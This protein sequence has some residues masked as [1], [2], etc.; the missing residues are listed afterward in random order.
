[1][2][3]K[4]HCRKHGKIGYI[5]NIFGRF[6]AK[7]VTYLSVIF[8]VRNQ[9]TEILFGSIKKK[10]R[11]RNVIWIF[12]RKKFSPKFHTLDPCE[13]K[14]HLCRLPDNT[15]NPYMSI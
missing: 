14:S 11:L 2:L 4:K 6:Y 10:I 12:A 13:M 8:A 5:F 9:I 7:S 3:L 1:M 15:S